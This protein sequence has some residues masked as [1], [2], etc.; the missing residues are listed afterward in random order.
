MSIGATMCIISGTMLRI[1]SFILEGQVE[2]TCVLDLTSSAFVEQNN[3]ILFGL[4]MYE[5]INLD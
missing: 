5:D 3:V 1:L 2:V 4:N